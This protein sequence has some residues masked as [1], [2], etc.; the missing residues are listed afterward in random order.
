MSDPAITLLCFNDIYRE[1][2]NALATGD[3]QQM[4]DALIDVVEFIGDLTLTMSGEFDEPDGE[5]EEA[6]WL[7][8]MLEPLYDDLSRRTPRADRYG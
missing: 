7:F 4:E 1:A 6:M 2:T 8:D 5:R 3:R